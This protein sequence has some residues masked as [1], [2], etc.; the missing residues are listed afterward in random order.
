MDREYVRRMLI[1]DFGNTSEGSVER[2]VAYIRQG[3]K[4]AFKYYPFLTGRLGPLTHATKK[5]QVQLRYGDSAATRA[6]TPAI[7]KW[8]LHA[9]NE[10]SP[11]YSFLCARGMPVS[12]W[13]MDDYCAAPEE[14]E[15]EDWPQALTLQANFRMDGALVLCLAYLQCVA[16]DVSIHQFLEKFAAGIRGS[17]IAQHSNI[18]EYKAPKLDKYIVPGAVGRFND[19]PEW[20]CIEEHKGERG[21][22]EHPR[23]S[24]IYTIPARKIQTVN[25]AMNRWAGA[26]HISAID[27]IC[28]IFW[29]ELTRA[30]FGVDDESYLENTRVFITTDVRGILRPPLP[31][32]YFGN[33]LAR[34]VAR[35]HAESMLPPVHPEHN[36]GCNG[37]KFAIAGLIV[38]QAIS[39]INKAY[40]QRR[41]ALL[42][43][44]E[45]PVQASEAC[46][47]AAQSQSEDMMFESLDY[48]AADINFGIPGAGI[49]GDGRPRWIRIPWMALEG[50][51]YVLPRRRGLDA[52]WEVLVCLGYP[53]SRVLLHDSRL[54]QW[55]FSFT[56]DA[57]ALRGYHRYGR[58]F[59][60]R[61]VTEATGL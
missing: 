28:A 51:V 15:V 60:N 48:F 34:A 50:A 19:F 55:A 9:E 52:N 31:K 23:E 40:V 1:F 29:V 13:K 53:E 38:R 35:Y 42:E 8:K 37:R 18:G 10:L 14:F 56:Q 21:I 41:M 25:A 12:H 32:S 30:R 16:N 36:P 59:G 26:T 7:F 46:R 44:L 33:M 45:E 27:S 6:I 39:S 54:G 5:N 4:V 49:D 24:F 47:R 22:D 61:R 11:S 17:P 20:G 43:Q 2:V 57:D 3:F 58:W